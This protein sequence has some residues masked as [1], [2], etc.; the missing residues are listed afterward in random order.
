M[1]TRTSGVKGKQGFASMNPDLQRDI[2]SLGG[3]SQGKHNNPGN[4]ARDKDKAKRAGKA[5]G[6]ISRR[7]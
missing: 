3:R 7:S 6:S 2:A 4:F 5:G 1:T